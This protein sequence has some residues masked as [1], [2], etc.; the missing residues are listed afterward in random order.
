MTGI[1]LHHGTSFAFCSLLDISY[2]ILAP[3][4]KNLLHHRFS[5]VEEFIG[6]VTEPFELSVADIFRIDGRNLKSDESVN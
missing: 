5:V 1:N 4:V 3:S 6:P 2:G